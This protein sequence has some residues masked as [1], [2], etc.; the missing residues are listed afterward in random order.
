MDQQ[1][2]GT[3]LSST[4]AAGGA[5]AQLGAAA[6]S[7]GDLVARVGNDPALLRRLPDIFESMAMRKLE[8]LA[9]AAAH[10]DL[11]QAERDAHALKGSLAMIGAQ[12]ASAQAARLESMAQQGDALPIET[13]LPR[14]RDEID[15]VARVLRNAA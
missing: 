7:Y 10:G 15:R 3:R 13:L 9:G 2:S 11:G 6:Y 8:S 14:L 5:D 1:A 12:A 4:P